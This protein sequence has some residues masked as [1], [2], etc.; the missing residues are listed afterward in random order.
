MKTFLTIIF[1]LQNY[2]VPLSNLD[3]EKVIIYNNSNNIIYKI[4][5]SKQEVY[6]Q[7]VN[8]EV[9]LN[10]VTFILTNYNGG[11]VIEKYASP[12]TYSPHNPNNKMICKLFGISVKNILQNNVKIVYTKD[13]IAHN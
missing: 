12:Y 6:I 11:D 5:F 10:N 4:D 9:I 13:N 1:L 8:K 7:D 3:K 2:F